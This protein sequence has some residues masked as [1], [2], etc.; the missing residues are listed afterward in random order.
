MVL[1]RKLMLFMYIVLPVIPCIFIYL[2]NT[3]NLNS[4]L[5]LSTRMTGAISYTWIMIQFIT[6]SRPNIL[7]KYYWDDEYY[8][9]HS[10]MGIVSVVLGILH[11]VLEF[12]AGKGVYIISYV[13]C[14]LTALFVVVEV[15]AILFLADKGLLKSNIINNKVNMKIGKYKYKIM[16]HRIMIIIAVM[17]FV[18]M[19]LSIARLEV[20]AIFSIYFI[21]PILLYSFYLYNKRRKDKIYNEKCSCEV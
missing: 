9:Y 13:G 10:V 19:Q 14:L 11:A 7:I 1:K 8:K 5:A 3:G 16:I 17:L 15:M 2:T 4:F 20:K 21:F 18:H 12:I 6:A